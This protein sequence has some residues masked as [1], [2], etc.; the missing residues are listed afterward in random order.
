MILALSSLVKGMT[1]P[2][3]NARECEKV[4]VSK[5]IPNKKALQVRNLQGF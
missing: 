1:N 4:M 5:P 2:V 3:G